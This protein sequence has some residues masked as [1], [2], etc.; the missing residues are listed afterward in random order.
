[1][2]R[3]PAHRTASHVP[4]RVHLITERARLTRHRPDLGGASSQRVAAGA[5]RGD[6][7]PRNHRGPR[8]L[9][10]AGSAGGERRGQGGRG[11]R[12]E[13][14]RRVRAGGGGETGDRGGGGAVVAGGH[15][16]EVRAVIRA[17][18]QLVQGRVDLAE[19]VARDLVGDR[20]DRAEL[21]RRRGRAAD[22]VPARAAR[23]VR[24]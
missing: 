23:P 11:R 15:V 14:G 19:A 6:R 12:A 17:G 20:D 3:A 13:G 22:H 1:A 18:G 7:G 5:Q 16:V 4:S 8:S 10:G 9:S 24:P 21:R 2:R